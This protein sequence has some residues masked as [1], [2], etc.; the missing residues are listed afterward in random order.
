MIS[1]RHSFVFFLSFD[2]DCGVWENI[3]GLGAKE[4][5]HMYIRVFVICFV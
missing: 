1:D 5:L 4:A 3:W 2:F